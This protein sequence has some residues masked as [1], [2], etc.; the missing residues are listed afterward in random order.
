MKN[1]RKKVDEQTNGTVPR[2]MLAQTQKY[3]LKV[4]NFK[5][6]KSVKQVE[7]GQRKRFS[8]GFMC[9]KPQD[10]KIQKFLP[11]LIFSAPGLH[12][13]KTTG[14]ELFRRKPEQPTNEKTKIST[15]NFLACLK[16]SSKWI[17]FFLWDSWNFSTYFFLCGSEVN[18]DF[19]F[20]VWFFDD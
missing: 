4:S 16:V 5:R 2:K 13:G 15:G 6:K 9:L 18:L 1:F 10:Q 3:W 14:D 11:Q 12:R 7:T 19:L 17:P 20:C 8:Y